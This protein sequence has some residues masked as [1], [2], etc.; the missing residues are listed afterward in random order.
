M[1]RLSELLARQGAGAVGPAD[2]ALDGLLLP[3]AASVE[4]VETL[5]QAGPYGS[6]APGPRFALPDMMVRH[7]REVGSGHL[8]L[9]LSDGNNGT[10]EAIAFGA[11]DGPL[12]TQLNSRQSDRFHVAGRLDINT[13]GGRQTVQLRLEDAARVVPE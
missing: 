7:A 3:G 9:S 1:E 4:L 2:L 8:K 13:W 11:F 5:E 10:I 12:G 6:G